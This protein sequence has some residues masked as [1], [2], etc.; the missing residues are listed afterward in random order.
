MPLHQKRHPTDGNVLRVVAKR[1]EPLLQ[2]QI[3]AREID[4]VAELFGGT[5]REGA[6]RKLVMS[7]FAAGRGAGLRR[8]GAPLAHSG[9]LPLRLAHALVQLHAGL[10][11]DR[12]F[13]LVLVVNAERHSDEGEILVAEEKQRVPGLVEINGGEGQMNFFGSRIFRDDTG[14]F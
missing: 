4:G 3:A 7:A 11:R 1:R 14:Y 10:P 5:L 2:F 6:G 12:G 13:A 8:K 9:F